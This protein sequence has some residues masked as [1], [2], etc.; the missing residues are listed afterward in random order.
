MLPWVPGPIVLPARA[1]VDYP[2][3]KSQKI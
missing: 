3:R 1:Y 2:M